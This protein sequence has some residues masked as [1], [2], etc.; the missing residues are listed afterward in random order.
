MRGIGEILKHSGSDK[1][2]GH[3]YDLVYGPLFEKIRRFTAERG[4]DLKRHLTKGFT[5]PTGR[6][7]PRLGNSPTLSTGPGSA[8]SLP[9]PW[10]VRHGTSSDLRYG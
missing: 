7:S 4:E 8:F 10:L 6:S 5:S 1:A 2:T 3:S 9:S